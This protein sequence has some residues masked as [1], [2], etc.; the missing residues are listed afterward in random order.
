VAFNHIRQS[1]SSSKKTS[2]TS[3]SAG[4]YALHQRKPLLRMIHIQA[5]SARLSLALGNLVLSD[6]ASKA[7]LPLDDA[8][9]LLLVPSAAPLDDMRASECQR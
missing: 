8:L 2:L 6:G 7:L 3:P 1:N 4:D 9:D 5:R